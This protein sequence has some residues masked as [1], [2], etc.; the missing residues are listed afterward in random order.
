MG[1]GR[2]LQTAAKA[3]SR[4]RRSSTKA[5]GKRDYDQFRREKLYI[6]YLQSDAE[7]KAA[8]AHIESLS[9]NLLALDFETV[10]RNGSFNPL[11][12]SLRLIQVGL[13]EPGIKPQ[14][15]LI[16]CY[17]ADPRPLVPLLRSSHVEKQIH[18]MSFEQK[19]S[20]VHLGT[21]IGNV[22]DTKIAWHEIQ[23]QLKKM[24]PE[25]IQLVLP[26]WESH[27][28][29]LGTLIKNYMN[30][31]IPKA[32]GASDWGRRELSAEQI[33]Y[34]A[35]DVATLPE[36]VAKTKEIAEALGISD[37]IDRATA[38]T[39]TTNAKTVSRWRPDE[40]DES[41]RVLAAI[42]RAQSPGELA[43]LL[44]SARQMSV[45][46]PNAR[47]AAQAARKRSRALSSLPA[48]S[49]EPELPF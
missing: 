3:T 37:Q 25:E 24:T 45:S 31:E 7:V 8:V 26:S 20:M 41:P 40:S 42:E 36:L 39:K 1:R 19:W 33:I 13:D 16:D 14:Q 43:T 27:D 34:A 23:K 2:G 15:I 11:S 18:N 6:N 29:K 4:A 28:N 21:P 49:Y 12:G 44:E 46:A 35:M 38:A 22:Y 9:P 32:H 47:K 10:T 5:S 30:M 48:E 17:S